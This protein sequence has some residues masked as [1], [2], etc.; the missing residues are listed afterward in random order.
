MPEVDEKERQL[1]ILKAPFDTYFDKDANSRV[2]YYIQSKFCH[3]DFGYAITVHASQGSQWDNVIFLDDKLFNWPS[4][5]K[6]RRKLL[7]TAITRAAEKLTIYSG[8]NA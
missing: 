1:E 7:Y 5:K 6:D 4:K 3:F 8:K 2:P